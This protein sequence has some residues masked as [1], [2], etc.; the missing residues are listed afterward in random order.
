MNLSSFILSLTSLQNIG[1]KM[2]RR[3][4]KSE[5]ALLRTLWKEGQ[6][7]SE[8]ARRLQRTPGSIKNKAQNLKVRR[9]RKEKNVTA[10]TPF[11]V[12]EFTEKELMEYDGVPS[13]RWCCSC[14]RTI[15]FDDKIICCTQ[16][17]VVWSH[18]KCMGVTKQQAKDP[19]YDH[20]C[21][22][23]LGQSKGNAVEKDQE[24]RTAVQMVQPLEI[25][26]DATDNCQE[27]ERLFEIGAESAR[28]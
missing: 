18:P 13:D 20:K 12:V 14:D 17:E 6:S 22:V 23:C 7:S 28:Y 3:W 2:P 26:D 15:D 4:T 9:L 8:I 25:E 10:Y 19:K 11:T 21:Y 5:E 16:C 24:P 27:R 1:Y